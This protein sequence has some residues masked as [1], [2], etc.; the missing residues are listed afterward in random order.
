MDVAAFILSLVALLATALVGYLTLHLT[1]QSTST[2]VLIDL[3][4]EHRSDRLAQARRYVN[5]VLPTYSVGPQGL[6]QLPEN[7]RL[8]VRDLCWFY[9]NLGVLVHYEV[10]DVV[11]IAGYLGGSVK[12][13][14][15]KV[16]PWVEAER[17]KR[18]AAGSAD[19]GRWQE[20]FEI[21]YDKVD[22][23]DLPSFRSPLRLPWYKRIV[24]HV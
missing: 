22:A 17:A 7:D 12:D 13:V 3:F 24:R 2:R 18:L 14:W 10:V 16:K 11:P 4:T 9:D 19:A 15:I 8:L 1:R 6:D 21:L 20:Y 5:E 23:F